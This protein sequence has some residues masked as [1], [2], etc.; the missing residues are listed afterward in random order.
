MLLRALSSSASSLL[1]MRSRKDVLLSLTT[2][3]HFGREKWT[4]CWTWASPSI[5]A[6]QPLF[7]NSFR[8]MKIVIMAPPSGYGDK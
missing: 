3:N 5:P 7:I 6:T 2:E 1:G 4:S 8:Q